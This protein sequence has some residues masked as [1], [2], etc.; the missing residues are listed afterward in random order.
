MSDLPGGLHFDGQR[1][2]DPGPVPGVVRYYPV[3]SVEPVVTRRSWWS[4]LWGTVLG[5][6]VAPVVFVVAGY[7]V[8]QLDEVRWHALVALG[9][10]GLLVGLVCQGRLSP[11]APGACALVSL[12]GCVVAEVRPVWLLPVLR[13]VFESGVP[14][15]VGVL[16]AVVAVLRR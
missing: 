9:F 14:V 4:H 5:L 6:V 12:A 1:D 13:P 15:G 7:G 16:L 8:D 11:A 2:V 3:S 10:A